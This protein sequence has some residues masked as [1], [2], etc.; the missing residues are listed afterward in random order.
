MLEFHPALGVISR[1]PEA[2]R[3]LIEVRKFYPILSG[4]YFTSFFNRI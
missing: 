4:F 1:I 3:Y 2:I